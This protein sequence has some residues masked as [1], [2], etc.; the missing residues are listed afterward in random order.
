MVKNLVEHNL[1]LYLKNFHNLLNIQ[2]VI[3]LTKSKKKN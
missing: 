3:S 1:S 2:K